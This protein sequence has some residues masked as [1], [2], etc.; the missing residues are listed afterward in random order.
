M[1][2]SRT[3]SEHVSLRE[4]SISSS[5]FGE[6][7]RVSVMTPH[8]AHDNTNKR[9]IRTLLVAELR[10]PVPTDSEVISTNVHMLPVDV[11][12]QHFRIALTGNAGQQPPLHNGRMPNF[13]DP[14]EPE[15]ENILVTVACG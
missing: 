14:L 8:E 13:L 7:N 12:E 15:M 5:L 10:V 6:K 2:M 9:T 11:L 1:P 4:T 3:S